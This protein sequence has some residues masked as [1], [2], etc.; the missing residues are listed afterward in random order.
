MDQRAI[1]FIL[2]EGDPWVQ[3]ITRHR[4][5]H[6]SSGLLAALREQVL[7]DRRIQQLLDS[8]ENFHERVV[9]G[10]KDP[11]LSISQLLFLLDLGLEHDIPQ[12]QRAVQAI[13]SHRDADS[14]YQSRVL[15]PKQYGGSGQETFG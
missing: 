6:E 11:S 8:V 5:L 4:L 12:I 7:A 13:L 10:H 14:V 15:V 1:R 3:Y 9:S 2:A